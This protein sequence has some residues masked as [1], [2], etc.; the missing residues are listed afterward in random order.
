MYGLG[1]LCGILKGTFEI[2]HGISKPYIKRYNFHTMLEFYE[3][4]DS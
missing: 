3:I 1:I 2:P 4:V